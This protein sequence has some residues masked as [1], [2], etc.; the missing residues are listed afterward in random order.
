MTFAETQ[1]VINAIDD[2]ETWVKGI[3]RLEADTDP[4]W[5]LLKNYKRLL[6]DAK[7]TVFELCIK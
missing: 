5:D 4:D 1:K 6:A 2:I 3:K 7:Q